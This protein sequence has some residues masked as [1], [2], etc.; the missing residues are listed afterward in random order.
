M[1]V[2]FNCVVAKQTAQLGFGKDVVALRVRAFC[3]GFRLRDHAIILPLARVMRH[4]EA[5]AQGN[6]QSQ[7]RTQ[8]HF[9]YRR[10]GQDDASAKV[11]LALLA[12]N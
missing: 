4:T 10:R 11:M 9:S 3:V 6:A 1:A 12:C 2:Q 8:Q 7:N 5:R